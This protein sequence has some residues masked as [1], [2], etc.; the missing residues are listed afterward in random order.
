MLVDETDLMFAA[1]MIGNVAPYVLLRRERRLVMWW[2]VPAPSN[3][4]P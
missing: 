2:T 1:L 3:E 4:V